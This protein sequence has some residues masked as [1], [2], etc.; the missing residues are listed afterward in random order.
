MGY[1]SVGHSQYRSAIAPGPCFVGRLNGRM[2]P[3][4]SRRVGIPTCPT[5]LN[6]CNE[7]LKEDR[8]ERQ[9]AKQSNAG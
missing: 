4:V 9:Y 7:A 6:E 2:D 5:R 8:N 3:T 1:G